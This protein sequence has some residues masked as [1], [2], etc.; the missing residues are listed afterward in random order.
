MDFFQ[1][2]MGRKYYEHD[3]PEISRQ[4]KRIADAL[5]KQNYLKEM[6]LSEKE[7]Q[8][9]VEKM[10]IHNVSQEEK[11]KELD[12]LMVLFRLISDVKRNIDWDEI[13]SNAVSVAYGFEDECGWYIQTVCGEEH[14]GNCCVCTSFVHTH[15]LKLEEVELFAKKLANAL[16]LDL[17]KWGC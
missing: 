8:A 1:T 5:E 17:E 15:N 3:V 11:S 12:E 13:N 10:E 16:S 2:I 6:E 4:L 9:P 7:N 14:T